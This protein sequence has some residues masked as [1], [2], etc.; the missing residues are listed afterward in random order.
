MYMMYMMYIFVYIYIM[1]FSRV[2][3]SSPNEIMGMPL[4]HGGAGT[5]AT[6]F[7]PRRCRRKS[8]VLLAVIEWAGRMEQKVEEP[9]P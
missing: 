1:Y 8:M 7:T 9:I 4:D 6:R 3:V 5:A 2:S